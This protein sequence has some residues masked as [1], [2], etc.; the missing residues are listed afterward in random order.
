MARLIEGLGCI[1]TSRYAYVRNLRDR[2]RVAPVVLLIGA[3]CIKSGAC[4]G[5]DLKSDQFVMAQNS[6]GLVS[7]VDSKGVRTYRNS[8]C[9][10][11][12]RNLSEPQRAIPLEKPNSS[13]NPR[14]EKSSTNAKARMGSEYHENAGDVCRLWA[15]MAI[16]PPPY[17]SADSK[18]VRI[19]PTADRANLAVAATAGLGARSAVCNCVFKPGDADLPSAVRLIEK[20]LCV[21]R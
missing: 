17:S 1:P 2:Y 11:G 7:C 20:P 14:Q 16:A 5:I 4:L 10:D 12:E 8:P 15:R 19:A 9:S 21:S 6:G 13:S 3:L 18:V